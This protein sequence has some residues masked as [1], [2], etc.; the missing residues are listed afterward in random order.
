MKE[1]KLIIKADIYILVGIH[2]TK[3]HAN[4]L[5]IYVQAIKHFAIIINIA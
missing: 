3:L 4:I 1:F 2:G 5:F